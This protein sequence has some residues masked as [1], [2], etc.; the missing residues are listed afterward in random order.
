MMLLG[1]PHVWAHVCCSQPAGK[2]QRTASWRCST[3]TYINPRHL[4]R[5]ELCEVPRRGPLSCDFSSFGGSGLGGSSWGSGCSGGGSGGGGNSSGDPGGS[6]GNGGRP[7]P[8]QQHQAAP[9]PAQERQNISRFFEEAHPATAPLAAPHAAQPEPAAAAGGAVAAADEH[10]RDSGG[11][12][13]EQPDPWRCECVSFPAELY[14]CSFCSLTLCM[15]LISLDPF[16]NFGKALTTCC[17]ELWHMQPLCK[18]HHFS[19]HLLPQ[20]LRQGGAG[21]AARRA[22]RLALCGRPAATRRPGCCRV[23]RGYSLSAAARQAAQAAGIACGIRRRLRTERWVG[24]RRRQR[25]RQRR[26]GWSERLEAPAAAAAG[27][28]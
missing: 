14:G 16:A 15:R 21:G 12:A 8:S 19:F 11:A 26:Q 1:D 10:L 18:G 7:S 24:R 2:A 20:A 28:H 13:D 27:H 22:Q 4:L 6:C 23:I 17:G 9:A 25:Q 3:C 5:C